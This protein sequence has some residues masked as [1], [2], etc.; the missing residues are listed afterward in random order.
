MLF[1]LLRRTILLCFALCFC[2]TPFFVNEYLARL[3]GHLSE[4]NIQIQKYQETATISNKTLVEY[5]AKFLAQEDKDFKHQGE[6]IQEAQKR[7]EFLQ[8][9]VT[10][11]TTSSP[12]I[13]PIVFIRYADVTIVR[14][15]W[16]GF[17]IGLSIGKESLLWAC[18][19]LIVGYMALASIRQIFRRQPSTL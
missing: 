11:I 10:S 3:E 2:Q 13:R 8:Q 18:I 17:S 16:Q 6:L 5:V 14:E 12:Y 7:N 9:A 1:K 19:G 4:S 15:T